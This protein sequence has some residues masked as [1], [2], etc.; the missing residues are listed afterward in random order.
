MLRPCRRH[1]F[2][3]ALDE[4]S[5]RNVLK[6]LLDPSADERTARVVATRVALALDFVCSGEQPDTE[7]NADNA[8]TPQQVAHESPPDSGSSARTAV[9]PVRRGNCNSSPTWSEESLLSGASSGRR[10]SL[11][12]ASSSSARKR[13]RRPR[14]LAAAEGG[15]VYRPPSYLRPVMQ[16]PREVRRVRGTI[17]AQTSAATI[18]AHYRGYVVRRWQAQ[19]AA[20]QVIQAGVRVWRARARLSQLRLAAERR[21]RA[22]AEAEEQRLI[23]EAVRRQRQQEQEAIALRTAR[24]KQKLEAQLAAVAQVGELPGGRSKYHF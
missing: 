10:H 14:G 2:I 20:A 1:S 8:K 15:A 22:L 12:S 17:R 11:S 7:A 16:E 19:L 21:K 9:G 5:V 6:S 23:E 13:S 4:V 24:A 18:Q 3:D